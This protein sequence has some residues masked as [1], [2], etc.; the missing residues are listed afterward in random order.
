M[1]LN[2]TM[3]APPPGTTFELFEEYG[4][5]QTPTAWVLNALD[6]VGFHTKLSLYSEQYMFSDTRMSNMTLKI[7]SNSPVADVSKDIIISFSQNHI[8]YFVTLLQ[9][10]ARGCSLIYPQCNQNHGLDPA[11]LA[12]GDA[13]SIALTANATG[14]DSRKQTIADGEEWN[15][16]DHIPRRWEMTYPITID[17]YY[18]PLTKIL[19]FTY[20]ADIARQC[21]YS[22]WITNAPLDILIAAED[23][24]ET[25]NITQIDVA[26]QHT[27]I[28]GIS[29][30][31]NTTSTL[32]PTPQPSIPPTITESAH[33][34]SLPTAQPSIPPTVAKTA[35]PSPSPT[36][37]PS[38][39]PTTSPTNDTFE[40][41]SM[42]P[43]NDPSGPPTDTSMDLTTSTTIVSSELWSTPPTSLP[44][45][46]PSVAPT[47]LSNVSFNDSNP[48]DY[49]NLG[50]GRVIE[51]TP[52]INEEDT[53]FM[54]DGA[55]VLATVGGIEGCAVG[56][57]DG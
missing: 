36:L 17:L 13:E 39:L 27:S 30:S 52:Q 3:N 54:N 32:S 16:I 1:S 5:I 6:E 41:S 4:A 51:T 26:M 45:T 12:A 25:F 47:T 28:P 15:C 18:D 42:N 7:Y 55:A 2:P 46:R 31:S 24:G 57:D 21:E 9:I 22:G 29:P 23:T 33:P 35:A 44:T 48:T 14:F 11:T 53:G 37:I 8:Q 40:L 34:S 49:T 50:A 38:T 43:T 19:T 10:D 20:F 56:N